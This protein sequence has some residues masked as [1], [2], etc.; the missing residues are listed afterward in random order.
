MNTERRETL[1]QV[2]QTAWGLFRAEAGRRTFADALA[3]AWRW[4]KN[5][6]AR[7]AANAA[8]AARNRGRTVSYGTMLQSPIRRSL[9]A[10]P[11]A[12]RRAGEAGYVTSMIGR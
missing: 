7:A 8:W 1:R 4:V 10:Q 3:G 5:S 2:M 9:G 12:G 6:A 11:Y